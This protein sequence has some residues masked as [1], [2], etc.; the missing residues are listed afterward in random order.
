MLFSDKFLLKK[1]ELLS[2]PCPFFS[3]FILLLS[4][5][6]N[7]SQDEGKKKILPTGE[8]CRR[9]INRQFNPTTVWR[10]PWDTLFIDIPFAHL[11]LSILSQIERG[12][13][14]VYGGARS[15]PALLSPSSG[16]ILLP[17]FSLEPLLVL[18][19]TTFDSFVFFFGMLGAMNFFHL[20]WLN[21]VDPSLID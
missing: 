5:Q 17:I 7:N 3:F 16:L 12:R 14:Q 21:I 9:S 8:D 6:E 2:N 18:K 4:Q 20:V 19:T 1:L 15:W 13:K 11:F 10:S